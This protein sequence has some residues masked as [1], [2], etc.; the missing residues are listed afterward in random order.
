MAQYELDC[1]AVS[2]DGKRPSI[3]ARERNVSEATVIDYLKRGLGSGLITH[4]QILFVFSEQVRQ[5]VLEFAGGPSSDKDQR[6]FLTA[7]KRSKDVSDAEASFLAHLGK[8]RH[9]FS[10][11]YSYLLEIE[12]YLFSSIRNGLIQQHGLGKEGRDWWNKGVPKEIRKECAARRE[13]DPENFCEDLLVYATFGELAQIFIKNWRSLSE[14]I[15]EQLC[16]GQKNLKSNLE[17]LQ[18]VR[19]RVMHPLKQPPDQMDFD[20]VLGFWKHVPDS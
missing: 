1:L 12:R 9:L 11:M 2:R 19:N 15:P 3:I 20:Q 17:A 6:E 13:C 5:L 14:N 10:E 7:L 16:S 8:P 4:S 18:R